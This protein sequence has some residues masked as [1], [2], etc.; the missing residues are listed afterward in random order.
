MRNFIVFFCCCILSC[1][2]SAANVFIDLSG[3][4]QSK[5]LQYSVDDAQSLLI[6][7][8]LNVSTAGDANADWKI[9]FLLN[10]DSVVYKSL[11]DSNTKESQ[12]FIIHS[13]QKN[14]QH[15]I[16]IASKSEKG[17]SNGLYYW[18]QNYLGFQFYHPKETIIPDLSNYVPETFSVGITPRFD[19]LG[20]HIHSQ[21][22][23]EITE[24]L[25]NE[26]TPNGREE[27]KTYINWL[28]RNGQ[29]YFEFCLLRSVNLPEWIPYFKPV[30]EYAHER[31]IICGVDM[32][33]HMIQQRA[34]QLYKNFPSS[35]KKKDKQVLK[36]IS[37]LMQI[38]WD[39][40]NVELSTTEFSQK[41]Q[42]KIHRQQ[43]F[44][45]DN[46]AKKYNVKLTT[47]KHV[48]KEENLISNTKVKTTRTDM[49]SAYGLFVHTVMFYSL[50]DTSTPV[51]R[52]KDF[53]HLRTLL[54]E[55]KQYRDTWYFP[56]SAYWITFDASIPMFLTPYLDARLEDIIYCDTSGGIDGHITFS[57]GW[58]W[59][60]WL[61]DWSIARWCW[62]EN[63]SGQTTQ[64]RQTTKNTETETALQF[65]S[66]VVKDEK[67]VQFAGEV[68]DLQNKYIKNDEL[69]KVMDAQTITDEI[70][71]K[72][73]LEFHPRPE[74]PYKYIMNKAT[75]RELDFIRKKYVVGLDRYVQQYNLIR[76]KYSF[77]DT[78]KLIN[79]MLRSFD[80]VALRAEH[81]KN[82]L[83]YLITSRTNKINHTSEPIQLYLDNAK[84]IRE[85]GLAIVKQQENNYRYPASSIA[86]KKISK[87]VY[88]FGYLY[89]VSNLH[90]WERE[91]LQ[92]K[93]NK[94]KFWY[95]NIWD[96]LKIIGVKK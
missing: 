28:C 23:L 9:V 3:L 81:R 47:R 33:L 52:N 21:H 82:T 42:E 85:K 26:K 56:E 95:Q 74:Y 94:W 50:L 27:V 10:K 24:A 19:K 45:Y 18:L 41:D 44:L 79:E 88:N 84:A 91:E 93:N 5:L 66:Q 73:N 72:I 89:T 38:P 71:G 58:E 7:G 96:V 68:K 16:K 59:N 57:S 39:V 63:E 32:S 30:V 29:N 90:F 62:K 61:I 43:K 77:G 67:F 37:T 31:G 75:L 78:D 15:I 83:L 70:G 69:I 76:S 6:Q 80:I 49:D 36:N 4:Q 8:K 64:S 54:Q 53:S 46:L 2:L 92:A 22:P 51:Y 13:Y 40:W 20:F 11:Y 86:V 87:T 60:Y 17:L 1:T 48:V 55:S 12:R 14:Q 34:F 25:L 35:F 65:L